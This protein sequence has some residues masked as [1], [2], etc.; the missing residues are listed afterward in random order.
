M[1][2]FIQH[3]VP[4]PVHLQSLIANVQ[5]TDVPT[6]VAD[7]RTF[8]LNE[9]QQ[10]KPFSCPVLR[11]I[12]DNLSSFA[13]LIP[14]C[15]LGDGVVVLS[16]HDALARVRTLK[17]RQ[18]SRTDF[19][20]TR[21]SSSSD[22][23]GPPMGGA[24]ARLF[25]DNIAAIQPILDDVLTNAN[26]FDQQERVLK[27]VLRAHSSLLVH[28]LTKP[29]SANVAAGVPALAKLHAINHVTSKVVAAEL[30]KETGQEDELA[31]TALA[32][33]LP[34]STLLGFLDGSRLNVPN[35]LI[36]YNAYKQVRIPGCRVYT[37]TEILSNLTLLRSFIL[38]SIT[39][40]AALG[41][42]A[43]NLLALVDLATAIEEALPPAFLFKVLESVIPPSLH[44]SLEHF[45]ASIKG[46][47]VSSSPVPMG[48]L[49]LEAS[50]VHAAL[51]AIH[52]DRR[53]DLSQFGL[54]SSSLFSSISPASTSSS[55]TPLSSALKRKTQEY[56]ETDYY[57]EHY[58]KR[59]G[60]P[61]SSKPLRARKTMAAE[62]ADQVVPHAPRQVVV[63]SPSSPLLPSLPHLADC[64]SGRIAKWGR[65][66][67]SV[68]PLLKDF[69]EQHPKIPELPDHEILPVL[70]TARIGDDAF[71]RYAPTHASESLK[72]ALRTW[73]E[74]K[75]FKNYRVER[76]PD[77]R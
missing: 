51:K 10:D 18:R 31:V 38:V 47:I 46:W 20:S 23:S 4:T 54:Q 50:R 57:P 39:L 6:V 27:S 35:L 59:R 14:P 71:N 58:S 77:F 37:L 66:Y 61:S 13:H 28:S 17:D 60:K 74:N 8:T 22:S 72:R 29:I 41:L 7:L 16:L 30:L 9:S 26:D 76:P 15:D 48:H 55:L 19:G 68:T 69:K 12:N 56:R 73:F 53:R 32:A 11:T 36:C 3:M 75:N 44:A 5:P 70:L 63:R 42:Q 2:D 52:E 21:S 34:S 25:A 64:A 1:H 49:V 62:Q 43:Q 45:S 40:L 24:F 33:A 65:D 67:V